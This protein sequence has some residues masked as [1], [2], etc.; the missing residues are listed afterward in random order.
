[1]G[2]LELNTR[3]GALSSTTRMELF[4]T[5]YG[6]KLLVRQDGIG[7]E[8]HIVRF[9]LADGDF[10][11]RQLTGTCKTQFGTS[12]LTS[13]CFYDM[14]DVRG[15][16]DNGTVFE[17]TYVS[18][19]KSKILY[20]EIKSQPTVN[21]NY[22][23]SKE[24][25]FDIDFDIK[26][27]V[28]DY[29]SKQTLN[30]VEGQIIESE[31]RRGGPITG[32]PLPILDN[33]TEGECL[34]CTFIYN[35]DGTYFEDPQ[36]G[37]RLLDCWYDVCNASVVPGTWCANCPA[38]ELDDDFTM[39]KIAGGGSGIIGKWGDYIIGNQEQS[40]TG[41]QIGLDYNVLF[42]SK[43][44]VSGELIKPEDAMFYWYIQDLSSTNQIMK[45][46]KP[47]EIKTY[48]INGV[49]NYKFN[50]NNTKEIKNNHYWQRYNNTYAVT[51]G[52]KIPGVT[53]KILTN[54]F[55]VMGDPKHGWV[56]NKY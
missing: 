45:V 18:D 41:T 36:T 27:E 17:G 20:S 19:L 47:Y 55:Q 2:F 32:K 38:T 15:S 13:S 33:I 3:L 4:F 9:G 28:F 56:L 44:K 53:P 16:R 25:S 12:A 42:E 52:V 31:H 54:K 22:G 29:I 51:M 37:E 30:S 21:V 48:S 14:T 23:V 35:P 34:Y 5:D 1:M 11:Y 50:L 24:Q 8:D 40:T 6:K 49:N 43:S 39:A 10:D 7:I 26:L 46:I